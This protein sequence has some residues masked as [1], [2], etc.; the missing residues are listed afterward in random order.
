MRHAAMLR[1]L[2]FRRTS[3]AMC[4][5]RLYR[6]LANSTRKKLSIVETRAKTKLYLGTAVTISQMNGKDATMYVMEGVNGNFN[7]MGTDKCEKNVTVVCAGGGHSTK[8]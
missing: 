4:L 5:K 8:I 1:F 6:L 3:N 2:K 7:S